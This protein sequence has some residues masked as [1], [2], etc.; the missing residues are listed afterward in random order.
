VWFSGADSGLSAQLKSVD[1][2]GHERV[3]ARVPGL[4]VIQDIARDGHVLLTHENARTISVALGPGQNQERDLTVVNWTLVNAISPDGRQAL[5]E[6]EGTGSRPGYDIYVRPTDG[7]APV[8]IGQG[9]GDDFSP[10]MKWVLA[11]SDQLF[12]I[13]LGPGEPQQITHD[14]IAHADARFLP[15]GKGVVFTGT[16][17]GHK[18]R[19]YTQAIGSGSPRAISPEGVSGATPTADGKFVFGLSDIVALYPVDGKGAPR[20]VPSIHP[21]ESIAAVFPDRHSVLVVSAASHASLDVFRVDLAS[22]R[23]ELFKKLGPADSAG[24][25]MF[26][27]GSF[28]PDGKYYAYAYNRTLSELYAVEGLR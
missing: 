20:M 6:E 26:P 12:L 28:T 27:S 3:V 16:E 7:S 1:L 10:D 21:R 5:L 22:D 11:S 17:P 14:S 2:A 4:L 8:R 19:I 23:R 15:D 18:P 13:P 25:F 9:H 24:L